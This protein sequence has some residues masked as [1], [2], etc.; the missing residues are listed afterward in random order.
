MSKAR[1]VKR[2]DALAQEQRQSEAL[3][4]TGS[5]AP[6]D[7]ITRAIAEYRREKK[8]NP[9]QAFLDLFQQQHSE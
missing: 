8:A 3:R 5:Q 2:K 4:S 9:R 6:A 7:A 1:L